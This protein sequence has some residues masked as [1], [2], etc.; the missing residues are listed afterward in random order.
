M[1]L[2]IVG[3]PFF[4]VAAMFLGELP[5]LR[6]ML[7][8]LLRD[9]KFDLTKRHFRNNAGRHSKLREHLSIW[10]RFL[11]LSNTQKWPRYN[12]NLPDQA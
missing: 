2:Q 7:A 12:R 10:L 8:Q 3:F 1:I 9:R 6:K 11:H 4:A 5:K